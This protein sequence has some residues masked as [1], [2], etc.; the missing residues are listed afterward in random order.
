MAIPSI[1]AKSSIYLVPRIWQ[2]RCSSGWMG[3]TEFHIYMLCTALIDVLR[4]VRVYKIHF[5][6]PFVRWNNF[7]RSHA[8]TIFTFCQWLTSSTTLNISLSLSGR[9][10]FRSFSSLSISL[11]L[12]PLLVL[13]FHFVS[14]FVQLK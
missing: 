2:K 7:Y 12:V 3:C 6:Y 13:D 9:S 10:V 11:C 5:T 4:S 14:P 1:K 8:K